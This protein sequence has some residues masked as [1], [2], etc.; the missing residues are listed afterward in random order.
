[1]NEYNDH[2]QNNAMSEIALALAMAF[3]SI[4]VLTM[5][6]MGNGGK[7]AGAPSPA[8]DNGFRILA[9]SND[10]EVSDSSI[11]A[12]PEKLIIHFEGQYLDSRLRP[13]DPGELIEGTGWFL[14]I[15]PALSMADAV[16]ARKDLPTNDVTVISLNAAWMTALQKRPQQ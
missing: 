6:S 12:A 3:F 10:T 15:D 13:V 1:M 16:E 14:A 9:T 4:M 5:V 7:S 8:A 2:T 11:M